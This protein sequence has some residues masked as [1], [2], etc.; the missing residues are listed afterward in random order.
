M[1]NQRTAALKVPTVRYSDLIRKQLGD[2][3]GQIITKVVKLR[4]SQAS[5]SRF[6]HSQGGTFIVSLA[7]GEMKAILCAT[8]LSVGVKIPVSDMM[9]CK[10]AEFLFQMIPRTVK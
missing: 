2:L 10:G 7:R 1:L 5:N 8:E 9:V 6:G 4:K 3:G